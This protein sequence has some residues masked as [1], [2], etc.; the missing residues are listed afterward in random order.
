M[1]QSHLNHLSRVAVGAGAASPELPGKFRQ[2]RENGSFQ[3]FR[4]AARSMA[5]EAEA[6]KEVMVSHGLSE[7]VLTDLVG[8]LDQ[9]D[10]EMEAG[11]RGRR[12]HVGA[13]AELA[14]VVQEIM[15]AVRVLDGLN[16]VRFANDAEKLA[17]WESASNV[18]AAN[19]AS[20]DGPTPGPEQVRAAA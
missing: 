14:V 16:R 3:A 10:G 20:D 12:D 2:P 9:F 18:V 6:N 19:R 15:H 7:L 5:E 11:A 8:M 4:T 17:A 1:T 13:G